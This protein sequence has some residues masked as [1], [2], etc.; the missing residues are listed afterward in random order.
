MKK[1]PLLLAFF[2]L[3][4]IIQQAQNTSLNS[5]EILQGLKKLNTVG[6]VLY[7]AAH[8]DDENTR[9]L[10]YLAN[11]KKLRTGYLSLT[12]GDGGQ[13]L[14]GK[15]QGEPLGL[16]RTQELLAARRVDGAE[17][18]FTRANDFG[19][20]KN[21]EETFTFWNKDSILADVVLTIRRFKPEVIICRFPTTGEGGHGHHTASA[22]LALEAFDAAADPKRFP[23]QLKYVQVW[24]AKRI[25]WN[26][27]N[28]GTTNT[29]APDQLKID[30]GLFNPLIGKGYG[31]IAAESRSN[32][33]SQGFG[34]AKQRGS[35]IE[36]FKLLKGDSAKTDLF[37]GINTSWTKFKGLEK[38]QKLIDDCIK[39]YNPQS[40]GN[41]V[42]DLVSIY[43]QLQS[44]DDNNPNVNY[45]KQQKLKETES[46]LLACSGLWIEATAADHIG[47]SGQDVAITAQIVNR[48]KTNVKLNSISYLQSDTTTALSLKANELY[49]FKRKEKLSSSLPFS[50]PYWLN[51]KHDIGLYT[52]T[53]HAFIGKPENESA[54]KVT[55]DISIQDLN[56]K[57]E[58]PLVYK[59]TDPVKGEIYRPFEILPPATINIPEKV[60]VFTDASARNI[61]LTVKANAANTNGKVELKG[62]P[63]WNIT[64]KNPEFKL[65]NKGDEAIIEATIT[66]D[67]GAKDGKLEA[68][69]M[70]N[71]TAYNKSIKRIEY[72]HIPYQFILS[73]AEAGLVNI[74]LKKAGTTIGYVP[75]AGDDVPAALKQVGYNVTVLTDELLLNENL[76]KY[77]AIVSGVRAYNTNDRLQ[78]HY[79]KLMDYVKNGGNLIVQYNTNNRIGPVIAKIGPYP[80]TI[81]RDRVTNEKA[82]VKFNNEKHSVL[83]FPNIITPKDFEGWIQER[84]IY[85]ATEIDKQYDTIFTMSDPNEKASDGSLII[86]K[87][88]KGNFVYTG[89]VFFRELPAGIPGAYRLFVNLLSLPQNQN[90]E[91]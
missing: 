45:W 77:N 54:T 49:T 29:T 41:S 27:F 10:A 53:N 88:G 71:N 30:A 65:A 70:V 17:Q 80:F 44:L 58:R 59:S 21:P 5:A 11:E 25:F 91:R 33:K 47:I 52:V 9:L 19:F 86:G 12:R 50:N 34:T 16:I 37:E 62:S 15:E 89:L 68:S 18:F 56:L 6:S 24:Q 51:Q 87:Y 83:N 28:F 75:G 69:V 39:K 84:G 48:N 78:V 20:S 64:I 90:T 63:G 23:E 13:N 2:L 55:F 57:I 42:S 7:V 66:A 35:T 72:D 74:D 73:D 60:F 36:Y 82:E 81:S 43:K 26:T 8:P 31:E 3:G 22:I 61:A 85:F 4:H 67:K 1:Q 38:I 79:T 46:L 76:S 14:I 40:P 32:H